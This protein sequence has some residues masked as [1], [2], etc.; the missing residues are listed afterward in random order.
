MGSLNEG[1]GPWTRTMDR[2]DMVGVAEVGLLILRN[3]LLKT[4]TPAA[5]D[6]P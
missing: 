5:P 6:S 2:A 3:L 4:V 1:R